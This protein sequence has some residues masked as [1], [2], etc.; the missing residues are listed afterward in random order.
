MAILFDLLDHRNPEFITDT[1]RCVLK[2][3][4]ESF[5][6]T[7]VIGIREV[8]IFL[9][10]LRDFFFF[11]LYILAIV[12]HDH[13]IPLTSTSITIYPKQHTN[14]SFLGHGWDTCMKKRNVFCYGYKGN[15]SIEIVGYPL[16]FFLNVESIN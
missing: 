7:H 9:F 3:Y 10:L 4:I 13:S 15:K 12:D 14:L 11:V 6:A 2:E 8:S 5:M 1:T 16:T